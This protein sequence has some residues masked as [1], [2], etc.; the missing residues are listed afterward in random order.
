MLWNLLCKTCKVKIQIDLVFSF[1]PC[2]IMLNIFISIFSQIQL[3]LSSEFLPDL[4]CISP[5]RSRGWTHCLGC[6]CEWR[7]VSDS[8]LEWPLQRQCSWQHFPRRQCHGWPQRRWGGKTR[9]AEW[10]SRSSSMPPSHVTRSVMA[11]NMCLLWVVCVFIVAWLLSIH[12][13]IV[14]LLSRILPL[15][16]KNL[17]IFCGF[18]TWSQ[19]CSTFL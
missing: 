8:L 18:A 4:K 15:H 3:S 11:S 16:F 1:I 13:K 14:L 17:Q 2:F 19:C 10:R 12:L 9:S 6:G 5:Y 7:W